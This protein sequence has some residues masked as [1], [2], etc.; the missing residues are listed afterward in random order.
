MSPTQSIDNHISLY[1][2]Y[3][4]I[5]YYRV[6][7]IISLLFTPFWKTIS[8]FSRKFFQKILSLCMV[9]ILEWFLIKCWL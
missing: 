8:L 7:A 9:S 1:L 4:F 3:I 5:L 2:A 6:R